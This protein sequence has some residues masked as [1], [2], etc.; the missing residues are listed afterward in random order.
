L[1][2]GSTLLL[3]VGTQGDL[4]PGGAWPLVDAEAA[5]R[6]AELC[7]LARELSIRHG[8]VVCRHEMSPPGLPR[9]CGRG[10]RGATR[11]ADCAPAL[12]VRI[13][14][15]DTPP[16]DLARSHALYLATGCQ[17]AVDAAPAPRAAFDVLTAGVRD[18]VVCG[19]GLELGVAHV[20][21]ALLARRVRTHLALDA[22]AVV[23]AVC[24]QEM[25]AR[26]KRRL[27]DVATSATLARMLRRG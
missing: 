10:E 9:H 18:A 15:A 13:V 25:L 14:D 6:I 1:F 27:V 16:A 11:V 3:D 8:G 20:V 21:E 24:A 23:D 19:A 26:W 2:A 12:P 7:A 4:W 5:A 17:T 22:T